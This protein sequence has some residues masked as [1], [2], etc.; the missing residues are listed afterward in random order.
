[1]ARDGSGTYSLP[2]AAF[3]NGTTIDATD[4][5]SDFSDIASAL[6]QSMS[7]DGQ[8]TPTA[9]QPMAGFKHTGVGAASART[10]Y[11]RADQVIG[12]VLDY[13]ADTGTATAYA[14][15]PSPGIT[16]YVVGQRFAFKA[17]NANSGANPTLAVNSLT[18]G[19]IYM[20]DGTSLAA[21]DISANSLVEVLVA[22][23]TTGTPTFHI[24]SP[25]AAFLTKAGTQTITGNKTFTGTVDLTGATA[26][27]ATKTQATNSTAL[28]STAYADRVAVQQVV[29]TITGAVATG[30][31]TV[32]FDDTIPQNTEGDQY[33]SLAIT[34]KSATSKLKITVVWNGTNSATT[35]VV[36]SL[37][38]DSTAN[39]LASAQRVV[40]AGN[41]DQ[42]VLV[43][44]M[45]SGTTS[46]TTFKVRAGGN[47]AGTTTFN[48]AGGSRLF[49]GVMASSITIEELGI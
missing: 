49:G 32:P 23:V 40:S 26:T 30:T 11:A 4:V 43:Y 47:G 39:A 31:T 38:Q 45:T 12:S 8:T 2:V 29:S 5:N 6:T 37:F 42:L 27:A 41:P 21:N 14:I 46:A 36:V 34:P 18:A 28:A 10:H 22:S 35:G 24:Q 3:V 19:I 33:M 7:K 15:A 13:A 17:I 48:G 25:V 9:D 16:A 1:M 20:P 44:E